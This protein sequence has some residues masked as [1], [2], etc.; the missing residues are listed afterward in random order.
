MQTV[1]KKTTVSDLV[2]KE[3]FPTSIPPLISVLHAKRYHDI[4]LKIFCLTVPKKIRRG[5]L[6][7]FKKFRVSKNFMHKGGGGL[8]RFSNEKKIPATVP[9]K[10]VGEPFGVSEN[11]WYRKMLGIREDGH[12][13]FPSK[14][15]CLTVPKHFVE[16][17]LCVSETLAYR[18]IVCIKWV[19]GISR[20][21]VRIFLS[22]RTEKVRRGT[23]PGFRKILLVSEK[24]RNF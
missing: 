3:F 7:C 21:S 11:F 22:H 17:P 12:H 2:F 18:K 10:I 19:R 8:L 20:F 23:L 6:R 5:T 1:K 24:N 4:P 9:K 13:D 15:F 16:E 14:L